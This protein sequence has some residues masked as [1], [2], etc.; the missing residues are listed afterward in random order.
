MQLLGTLGQESAS[1]AAA[2]TSWTLHDPQSFHFGSPAS[3]FGGIAVAG[4]G[5]IQR[6]NEVGPSRFRPV[7]NDLAQGRPIGGNRFFDF[8]LVLGYLLA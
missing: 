6:R 5:S 2:S 3:L 4:S 8:R 1:P 7:F